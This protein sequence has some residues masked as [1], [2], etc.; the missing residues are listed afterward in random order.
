MTVAPD[1]RD[2]VPAWAVDIL[3]QLASLNGRIARIEGMGAAAV[4]ALGILTLL[5][6]MGVLHS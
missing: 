3:T 4:G 6:I 1:T 2:P 5:A